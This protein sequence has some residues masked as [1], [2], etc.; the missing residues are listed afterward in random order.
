[1]YVV[2]KAWDKDRST[3]TE[4]LRD[5]KPTLDRLATILERH[6]QNFT[7]HEASYEKIMDAIREKA[8]QR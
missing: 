8:N 7:R 4:L 1:M 6:E 2:I 3:M 5:V